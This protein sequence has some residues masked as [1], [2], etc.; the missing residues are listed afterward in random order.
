MAVGVIEQFKGPFSA[1]STIITSGN[2]CKIGISI[3]QDDYYLL[4]STAGDRSFR[5]NIDGKQ[6]W[7][8][9]TYIYETGEQVSSTSSLISFPDGAPSSTIVDVLY[10]E[11]YANQYTNEE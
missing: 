1:G 8:G 5:F 11:A 7:M 4:G 2:H 6:I 3:G 9:R 10:C